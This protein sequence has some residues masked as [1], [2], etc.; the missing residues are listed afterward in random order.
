MTGLYDK[1]EVRKDGEPIGDCFV[2]EPENDPAAAAALRTYAQATDDPELRE[3]L[4]EWLDGIRGGD[5]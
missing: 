5:A 1:Y 3:D 2:L 4:R